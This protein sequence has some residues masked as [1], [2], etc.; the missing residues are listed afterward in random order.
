MK[1][2]KV[3]ISVTVLQLRAATASRNTFTKKSLYGNK[4]PV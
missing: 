2:A 4:V 3:A 1:L